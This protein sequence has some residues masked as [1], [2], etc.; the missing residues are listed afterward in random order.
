M[1]VSKSNIK[2]G[3]TIIYQ[4]SH[5][6]APD[7]CVEFLVSVSPYIPRIVWGAVAWATYALVGPM[8]IL[9][10][11]MASGCASIMGLMGP[12]DM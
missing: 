6:V 4:N 9:Q 5:I 12:L 8:S 11:R 2:N 3:I 7:P 10:W 1:V